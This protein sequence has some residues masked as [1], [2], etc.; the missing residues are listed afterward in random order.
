M[1][2]SREQE[3]LMETPQFNEEQQGTAQR[4]KPSSY[5]PAVW[6]VVE[7]KEIDNSFEVDAYERLA[8]EHHISDPMF[9]DFDA[10]PVAGTSAA[11]E[12]QSVPSSAD[13]SEQIEQ[14]L[15]VL[16]NEQD[17]T[18]DNESISV[19]EEADLVASDESPEGI[20]DASELVD[21]GEVVAT[22]IDSDADAEEDI[23]EPAEALLVD[24]E[25]ENH[26]EIHQEHTVAEEAQ[27]PADAAYAEG[28]AVGRA[29][30]AEMKVHMEA[31]YEELL[32]D[33]RAQFKETLHN[34]ERQAV[35]LAFQVAQK[36][37]GS[38]LDTDREYIRGIVAQALQAASGSEII[39]VRVSPQDFE[40]LS[41]NKV[42]EAIRAKQG[43]TWSFQSDDSIRAGCI[44]MTQAGEVDFDLDATWNRMREK[45]L[46]GPKS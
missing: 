16:L 42:A 36:L 13:E 21:E 11:V 15:K 3:G 14:D 40:F 30:M 6:P 25:T 19:V 10:E 38:T 34:V 26:E 4:V 24:T 37:V 41:L 46:R 39:T 17:T 7:S 45:V 27:V 32:A 20:E 29:E 22:A 1:E 28:L 9:A 44:V 23:S 33:M 5:T 18:I 43:G 35:E 12:D 31:R 2:S 8:Q